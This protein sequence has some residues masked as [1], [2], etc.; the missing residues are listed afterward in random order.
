MDYYQN[1]KILP[2]PEFPPHM[3]MS[4]LFAKLHRA[5]VQL[6]SNAIGVSFPKVDHGKPSLGNLLR[7]H[8]TEKSLQALEEQNWLVR[9][10][11]HIEAAEMISVPA[12]A[13]HCRVKRVQA[14]SSVER[15]RRRY[16]KRHEGVTA[17]DVVALIPDSV[18]A[19]LSLPYLQ[20]KSE[21]TGQSFR[22]FIEHQAPQSQLITGV[23]NSY[24]LS[25]QATVPWF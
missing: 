20:L 3:L 6:D 4:A 18:E 13:Q 17:Q 1:I 11:D 7:L 10:L 12:N 8:G 15:L 2:D 14:K 22:L 16:C 23:F 5:L 25:T 21:S 19:H 9:M 24:G